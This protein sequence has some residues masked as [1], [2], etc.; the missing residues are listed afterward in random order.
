MKKIKVTPL[1]L[2]ILV[3][4]ILLLFLGVYHYYLNRFEDHL[5]SCLVDN[6]KYY[7]KYNSNADNFV[8]GRGKII[9][10]VFVL[11]TGS[12][13]DNTSCYNKEGVVELENGIVIRKGNEVVFF[14]KKSPVT[15]ILKIYSK[16]YILALIFALVFAWIVFVLYM[17]FMRSVRI[18]ENS[19][20]HREVPSDTAPNIKGFSG[21]F[22]GISRLYDDLQK[23]ENEVNR[24]SKLESLGVLLSKILHDLNNVISTLKIYHYIMNNT[25]DDVKKQECLDKIN[26]SL[27][28]MT[29]M[30]S[31]TFSFVRGEKNN[32]STKVR[33]K[34]I[35]N[36]IKAEY[37]EKAELEK[38]NFQVQVADDLT[39]KLISVN[40]IQI[41]SALRNLIQNAFEELQECN[42]KQGD[43][44]LIIRFKRLIND[45]QI[46][47]QDN[48]RGLPVP[49]VE[50]L[51]TP[52][53]TEGKGEGTGLGISTAKEYV[54]QNGGSIDVETGINGTTFK[55][56]LPFVGINGNDKLHI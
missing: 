22:Q 39:N 31:E 48:G 12:M 54:E 32:L 23:T 50:R 5:L 24:K 43:K 14:S 45:L 38:V 33:V 6:S 8:K 18:L 21:I 30:V 55:I 36:S 17:H 16:F 41:M 42:N 34:D 27:E 29:E 1:S 10:N 11:D 4:V 56:I 20:H 28:N 19:I 15:R 53:V 3:V 35:S 9:D 44:K 47:I 49:V 40:T 52:F 7:T 51:F 25:D 2:T 13:P 37:E 26:D 46:E